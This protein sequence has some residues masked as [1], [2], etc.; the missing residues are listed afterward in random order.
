[1]ERSRSKKISAWVSVLAW[2][3]IIFSLSAMEGSASQGYSLFYFLERKTFHVIEYFILSS[4]LYLAYLQSFFWK[5]AIWLSALCAL[6]YA[7][8]DEWHQTFVFGRTGLP[9]DVLIDTVGI[10]LAVI[11]VLKFKIGKKYVSGNS[12][13]NS[14]N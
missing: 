9:R 14:K 6:L 10:L 11:L 12:G 7:S 5:K 2:M 4:L 1:M 8:S 3:I 13:K